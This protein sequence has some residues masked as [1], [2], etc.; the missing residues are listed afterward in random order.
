[1]EVLDGHVC[2]DGFLDCLEILLLGFSPCK[3]DI[4]PEESPDIGCNVG[5]IRN[6]H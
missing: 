3:C 6:K 5:Y 1:M 2:Y 4:F